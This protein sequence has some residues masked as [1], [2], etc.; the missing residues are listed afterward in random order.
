MVNKL[1]NLQKLFLLFS[2]I[3]L[4]TIQ[5]FL[6]SFY[7]NI[8]KDKQ[9]AAA[10]FFGESVATSIHL[11]LR[12]N[13]ILSDYLKGLYVKYHENFVNDFDLICEDIVLPSN[14]I[15]GIYIAPNGIIKGA[16]PKRNV[17]VSRNFSIFESPEM[18]SQA[19]ETVASKN[20]SI[21]GP[22]NL[23]EGG[24]GLVIRNPIY[25][26]GEFS[27]FLIV[28]VNW[29]SF[30]SD[31]LSRLPQENSGYHFAVW[32]NDV[33]NS[34]TDEYNYIFKNCNDDVSK[35]VNTNIIIPSDT[36]HLA[37]EPSNGWK[38]LSTM[39]HE[40]ALT[41]FLVV[42]I[43]GGILFRQISNN[44]KLYKAQHDD[45]TDLLS[46]ST[47]LKRTSVLLKNN[48]SEAICIVAADIENFKMTNSIYGTEKCDEILKYLASEY[49]S[50]SYNNLCTRFGSDYF[51]F[52]LKSK[53]TESDIQLLEEFEKTI[54]DNS[55]VEHLTVKYGYLGNIDKSA[56]IN[57][58]C[59]K[60]LLAAKSILHNYEKTIANYE[61]P[62]SIKNEKS[63]LFES[64]FL[65][66]LQNGD[67]KVW[68][69][70]KFDAFTEELVGAEALVRWI[71]SDGTVVSPTEFIHV[72]EDDGLIYKLDM[73]VFEKVCRYIKE[74]IEKGK[75][76]VPIS[77]NISRISLRHKNV[78]KEYEKIV[79]DVGISSEYVPLEITE[80]STTAS[81]QIK[82][83]TQDLKS[84][85]FKI[86]MDD[87]GTGLSSLESLNILPFDV[88]K[89]DKSLIDFIGTPVGEELLRHIIELVQFMDLKIIAEGVETKDQLE[90]LRKLKCNHIQ[91]YY[92]AAP[93]SYEKFIDYTTK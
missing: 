58:Q 30:V 92:Y 32:N 12:E 81:K 24:V 86:H 29:E 37:I 35:L 59:D 34:V 69:Q 44:K 60:A 52:V 65:S 56:P 68:F 33:K 28:V 2:A 53:G 41:I 90:F 16:Y 79:R 77:V 62:L 48:P 42:I 19:Y 8:E 17:E 76:V 15:S 71:K 78:I 51:I 89:L 75:Q 13:V 22:H 46:R 55:P 88:I 38:D 1:S 91:G 5:T 20:V 57:L 83:L 74:W 9:I 85:G 18:K 23:L 11:S 4:V 70:P 45:L 66:A 72:F 84:A 26:N 36:W 21:S 3:I 80:S 63:Q 47:F 25:E 67:F 93:M 10:R 43:L 27:A 87:F 73:Y 54:A 61:G 6:L 50:L 31:V 7:R 64:S 49:R 40:I 82:Q 39:Y 14:S